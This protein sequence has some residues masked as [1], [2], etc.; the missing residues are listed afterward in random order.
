M[1]NYDELKAQI[2]G[3]NSFSTCRKVGTQL[4]VVDRNAFLD[5]REYFGQKYGSLLLQFRHVIDYLIES[6]PSKE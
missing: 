5:E 2:A 3:I 6:Q 1:T 4:V